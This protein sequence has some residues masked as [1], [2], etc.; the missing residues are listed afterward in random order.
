MHGVYVLGSVKVGKLYI[1]SARDIKARLAEHNAGYVPAT[2][3]RRPFK[4]LYCELY[5]S[6][7]DAMH[8]EQYL[9]TGWGEKIS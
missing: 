8:R 3:A 1:G 5:A 7:I 4:L 2:K 6:R 9:K